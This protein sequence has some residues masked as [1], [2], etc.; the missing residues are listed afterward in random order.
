MFAGTKLHDL[1]GRVVTGA[2]ILHEGLGKW[3]ADEERA[4]GLHGAAAEAF[5]MFH[6]MQPKQF[7]TLLSTAEIATG[8]LL[9]APFVPTAL[10]G[11]ALTGFAGGLVTMYLRK[12]AM[13]KEGSVWPSQQG[14][15]VSKDSWMLGMGVGFVL[16]SVG[17]RAGRQ[18]RKVAKAARKLAKEQKAELKAA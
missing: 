8:T 12:P 2:Y 7:T 10:A 18:R 17:R 3:N 16:D 6:K 1:P 11:L 13:R 15:A 9:L 4:A 5:P 14:I